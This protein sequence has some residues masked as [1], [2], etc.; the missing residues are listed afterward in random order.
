M[1]MCVNECVRCFFVWSVW[2]SLML[3]CRNVFA[4]VF[5]WM[6]PMHMNMN[7]FDAWVYFF[8]YVFMY[9]CM[10]RNVFKMCVC[11]CMMFICS[12]E[13]VMRVWFLFGSAMCLQ[14]VFLH[15]CVMWLYTVC[16][17]MHTCVPQH[18]CEDLHLLF[19]LLAC[20][21]MCFNKKICVVDT[22]IC[23]FLWNKCACL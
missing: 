14:C 18:G 23:I 1:H 6:R 21:S 19:F 9:M 8:L 16:V 5:V 10:F 7:A 12:V 2:M 17:C 4:A 20:D 3:M 15:V 13:C 11:V 22:C